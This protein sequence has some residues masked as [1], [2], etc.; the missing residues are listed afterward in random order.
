[1]NTVTTQDHEVIDDALKKLDKLCDL[2]SD[3]Q[4]P[5]TLMINV[6]HIITVLK[7]HSSTVVAGR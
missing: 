1:M 3:S 7:K 6:C 2:L 4:E 5:R